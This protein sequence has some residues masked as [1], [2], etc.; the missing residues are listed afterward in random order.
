MN[1][2]ARF[3]TALRPLLVAAVVVL[4]FFGSATPAAAASSCGAMDPIGDARFD[5]PGFEDIRAAALT[6]TDASLVFSMQV[7]S[8]VPAQPPLA[9]P[10]VA[11]LRWFWPVQTD[12]TTAPRGFPEAP[13]Y[14]V[15]FQFEIYVANDGSGYYAQV[16]DRRPLLTGG[17]PIITDVPFTISGNALTVLVDPRLLGS[18]STFVWTAGTGALSGPVGSTGHHVVDILDSGVVAWPC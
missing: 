15:P 1:I 2:F 8:S 10:A 13:G 7:A 18:P 6:Q 5:A 9:P 17:D 11:G 4:P 3:A 14:A 16:I 12:P